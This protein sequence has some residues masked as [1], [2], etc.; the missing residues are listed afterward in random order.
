VEARANLTRALEGDARD[1]VRARAHLE[2]G[3]LADLDGHRDEALRRYRLAGRLAVS[4]RDDATAVE[5][6]R[7]TSRAYR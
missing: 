7:L 4:S 6:S 2:L 3:K 1:W 5:A